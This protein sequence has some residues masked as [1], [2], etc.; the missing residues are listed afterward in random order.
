MPK[1]QK[2]VPQSSCFN[3]EIHKCLEQT[4]EPQLLNISCVY[5][6]ESL[7]YTQEIS[8][9]CTTLLCMLW[10]REPS[11]LFGSLAPGFPD[12]EHAQECWAYTRDLL[13][14]HKKKLLCLFGSLASGFPGPEHAQ[15][16][17]ACT[18]DLLCIHRR[19]S[20][21]Y[22]RDIEQVRLI[23]FVRNWVYNLWQ[24]WE[25]RIVSSSFA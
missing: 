16:C 21:V 15:E 17:C 14:I 20:C 18:R 25:N 24:I 9:A 2:N 3:S 4:S 11:A 23:S 7:V 19:F 1:T 12:P 8:C 13:C 5:T 6:K 10:A 22:T